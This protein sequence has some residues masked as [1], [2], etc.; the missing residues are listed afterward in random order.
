MIQKKFQKHFV[1]PT[2]YGLKNV[3]VYMAF[4]HCKFLSDHSLFLKKL[5]IF[6][7]KYPYAEKGLHQKISNEIIP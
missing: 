1:N 4:L 6:V 2:L 3:A 5:A 7:L